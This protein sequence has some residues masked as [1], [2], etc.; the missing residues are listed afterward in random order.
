MAIKNTDR[1]LEAEDLSGKSG[2]AEWKKKQKS[3]STKR[4]SAYYFWYE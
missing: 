4:V 2:S 1:Q 3:S